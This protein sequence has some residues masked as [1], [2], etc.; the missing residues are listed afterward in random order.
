MLEKRIRRGE[1]FVDGDIT[2]LAIILGISGLVWAGILYLRGGLLGGL[3]A[4]MLAGV[5]FSVPFFKLPLGALP[6]TVDRVL[7]VV[8]VGQ[9][10]LFRRWGLADPKP[11]G[12]PEIV[13]GLFTAWMVVS[14]FRGDWTASDYQPVSWLII[15]YLMPFAVYWI[16]R[17]TPMNERSGLAILACL[18]LF[19]VYLAATALAE[20]F[21]AWS[22]VFPRYIVTTAS[23]NKLE[24]IGRGRGP[25][26][27]PIGN[28]ILL[29]ICLG[30]TL[31]WWP[32]LG[33]P[34]QLLLVP[35]VTL[36]LAGLY[37]SL[38]R[39]VWMSGLLAIALCVGL[40]MPRNWRWPVL[41]GG[42]LVAVVLAATQWENLVT[43]KRDRNLSAE[44]TADS[45]YL[46]P[47]LARLS[48]NMFLDHPLF[49]CG[50]TQYKIEH[51]DYTADRSTDLPL[52]KGRGYIP[53]NVVFSLLT[54][55]GLVGLGLFLAAVA[56]WGLDAWRLW[57]T[58]SARLWSRQIGL[59]FLVALGAYFVNGMFHDA[60]AVPMAN[61]TLFFLAG[62][63]AALRPMRQASPAAAAAASTAAFLPA[64]PRPS[65]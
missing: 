62:V 3:L 1:S 42:L 51:L 14:T 15:Y 9:Y 41:G 16:A 61:M 12:K 57:R 31:M 53:H 40:P 30:A 37:V 22:L 25:L 29:T 39:S 47:V 59:L 54:E 64:S 60:S 34:R 38:T 20:Y 56:M 44:Q 65:A 11:V 21:Q 5:C 6:L 28:G 49:G 46:R 26:L 55:T 17:Q 2:F 33:R 19:G 36:I 4:V 24:F 48:W 35:V 18:S 13:L 58:Q 23:E 52:A 63:T 7:L 8:L 10:I 27:T 50:Y 45:V 43:F 32:R